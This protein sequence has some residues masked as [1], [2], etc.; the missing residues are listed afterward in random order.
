MLRLAIDQVT[1][2]QQ[3]LH[4][5]TSATYEHG[6]TMAGSPERAWYSVAEVAQLLGVSRTTVWRWI[7]DGRLPARRVGPRTLRVERR[8][9]E[10][11]GPKSSA[12][13]VAVFDRSSERG[14]SEATRVYNLAEPFSSWSGSN[15]EPD[16]E[17]YLRPLDPVDQAQAARKRAALFKDYAPDSVRAALRDF[18][19][20]WADLDTDAII[21]ELHRAR[22][23]GTRPN[24]ER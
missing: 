20:S 1:R 16:S 23:A 14:V 2:L 13:D 8:V 5:A 22:A 6:G 3:L 9:V 7:R 10:A 15:I 19:G 17:A 21:A 24:G 11:A 4:Y 12:A 18:G